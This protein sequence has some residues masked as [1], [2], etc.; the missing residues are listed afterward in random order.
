MKYLYFSVVLSVVC[1]GILAANDALPTFIQQF[2]DFRYGDKVLH[3]FL[4]GSC[5]G[6]LILLA[7][8]NRPADPKRV[9]LITTISLVLATLEEFSQRA[10][11]H[12]TF[13]YKDLAANYMGI[14]S[15][16]AVVFTG[17]LLV[18]KMRQGSRVSPSPTTMR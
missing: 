14:V 18:E 17:M 3:F 2:Y 1:I 8:K 10:F 12:R 5:N 11:P 6:A 15:F 13:S 4:I 7:H 16:G 9:I